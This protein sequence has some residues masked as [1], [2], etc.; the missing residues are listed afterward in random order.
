MRNW[1]RPPD[2][3]RQCC[4]VSGGVNW[5]GPT[6]RQM[7]SAS[8]CVRWSHRQCLRRPT[9]SDAEHTCRAVGPTQFTPPHQTR[10]NGPIC[11]VSGVPVWIG[12]LLWTCSDFKFSVGDSLELSGIQ[13]TPPKRTRHRQDNFVVSGAGRCELA[14]TWP[15]TSGDCA[16]WLWVKWQVR[17]RRGRWE[18]RRVRGAGQFRRAGSH[19]QRAASCDHHRHVRRQ[20]LGHGDVPHDSCSLDV[21]L[22]QVLFITSS[23]WTH[24]Q[25]RQSTDRRLCPPRGTAT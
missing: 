1:D 10:Q 22:A 6:A 15:A 20:A 5:V 13:F 3:T 4:V 24:I 17:H 2:T 12:R 21:S 23:F 9:H 16:W 18:D 25:T 7:C 11:V 14:L 8:E 19:V